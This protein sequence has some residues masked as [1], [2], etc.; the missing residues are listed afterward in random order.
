MGC[1]E[2]RNIIDQI[3]NREIPENA[4]CDVM[5]HI[6]SCE[7]CNEYLKTTKTVELLLKS[8]NVVVPLHGDPFERF[9]RQLDEIVVRVPL[10]RLVLNHPFT[11]PAIVAGLVLV[12]VVVGGF[13]AYNANINASPSVA[14]K[15]ID[16]TL[17]KMP[18][19]AVLMKTSD[20]R[21]IIFLDPVL[22][23]EGKVDDVLRELQ[24]AMKTNPED[25]SEELHFAS[26]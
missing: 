20:G 24:E 12:A 10:W 15:K 6:E 11:K 13:S 18:D 3:T 9:N 14:D 7:S 2:V 19:G 23:A 5:D 22:E 25:T 17:I 4:L 21:E 26:N 8:C 16:A 1:I